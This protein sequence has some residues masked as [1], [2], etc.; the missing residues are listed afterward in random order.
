AIN[1]LGAVCVPINLAYRGGVLEHV[2]NNADAKVMVAHGDLVERL[3]GIGTAMLEKIVTI[4]GEPQ[5]ASA[6]QIVEQHVLDG[7]ASSLEPLE[8]PIQPWDLQCIV[9]TSGTT[10]PSKGVRSSYLHLY[11]CGEPYDFIDARDRYLVMLPLFH[12]GGTVAT[13]AMLMRGGSVAITDAFNAA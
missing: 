11:S 7:D 9:Y 8:R 6:L 10:G 13:Y 2:L 3:D 1:Y 12:V 4:R 5:S